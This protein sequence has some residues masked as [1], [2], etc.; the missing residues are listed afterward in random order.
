MQSYVEVKKQ[1]HLENFLSGKRAGRPPE[2]TPSLTPLNSE[3][4][5]V[6]TRNGEER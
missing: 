5:E 4:Q 2:S 6:E 3:S 1:R